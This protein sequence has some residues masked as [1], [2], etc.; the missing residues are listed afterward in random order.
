MLEIIFGIPQVLIL[1]PILFNIFL[2]GF[3]IIIEDTDVASYAD[4][5]EPYLSADDNTPYVSGDNIDGFIKS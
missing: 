2:V 1:R 3:F 4:D 5:N